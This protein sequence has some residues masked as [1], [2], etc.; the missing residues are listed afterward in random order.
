MGVGVKFRAIR[1]VL[2]RFART[3]PAMEMVYRSRF[4]RERE[5]SGLADEYY[6]VGSAANHS[7]LYF[8][9]RA[10]R[11]YHFPNILE[12]G[13]GQSSILIDRMART[14]AEPSRIC[15]VDHDAFWAGRIAEAVKHAVLHVPL[16]PMR[17]SGRDVGYYDLAGFA[18][19]RDVNLLIIDG[20]PASTFDLKW[21]RTGAAELVKS[22]LAEDFVV[23]ADD[24]E[25]PGEMALAR[26][27]YRHFDMLGL[28]Y[29]GTFIRALQCQTVIAAG[30]HIGAAF[31]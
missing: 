25:R 11:E 22:C 19:K 27:L 3:E 2:E 29:K 8:L 15:T 4:L 16:R 10:M 24:S 26:M 12:L 7:L 6:P 23:V 17:V 30:H 9:A 28:K 18:Q 31:F 5:R 21:S 13:A 1:T 14:R 20:P